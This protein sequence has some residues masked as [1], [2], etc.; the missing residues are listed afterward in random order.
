[1]EDAE[2]FLPPFTRAAFDCEKASDLRISGSAIPGFFHE[3][4]ALPVT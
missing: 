2:A 4:L 1:M 3:T